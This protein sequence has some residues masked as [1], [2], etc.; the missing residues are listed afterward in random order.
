MRSLQIRPCLVAAILCI[1]SPLSG[2]AQEPAVRGEVSY[3]T[4][5]VPGAFETL[6][7]SINDSMVVTGSYTATRMPPARLALYEAR[8]A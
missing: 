7:A 4:F 6:P 3:I 1:L 8:T 2:L 5:Q